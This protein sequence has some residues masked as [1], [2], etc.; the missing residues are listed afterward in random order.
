MSSGWLNRAVAL[1]PPRPGVD[2]ALAVGG[3]LPLLLRGTAP[4]GAW[5]PPVF[6]APEPDLYA[7]IAA[8]HRADAVTGPR[9]WR[10]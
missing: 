9:S 10:D 7:R 1:L 3:T 6:T 8:L 2:A 5:A 4:V